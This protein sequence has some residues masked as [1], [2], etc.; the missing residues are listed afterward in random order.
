MRIL[1]YHEG[2]ELDDFDDQDGLRTIDGASRDVLLKSV[3]LSIGIVSPEETLMNGRT[4]YKFKMRSINDGHRINL[5]FH[6]RQKGIR[7][8]IQLIITKKVFIISTVSA[9]SLYLYKEENKVAFGTPVSFSDYFQEATLLDP[10]KLFPVNARP[11]ADE[12]AQEQVLQGEHGAVASLA[13]SSIQNGTRDM[14]EASNPVDE[15]QLGTSDD[16]EKAEIERQ[17]ELLQDHHS[18]MGGPKLKLEDDVRSQSGGTGVENEGSQAA[19]DGDHIKTEVDETALGTLRFLWEDSGVGDGFGRVDQPVI[20]DRRSSV[21]PKRSFAILGR[22]VHTPWRTRARSKS[23]V[24][25]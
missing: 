24:C 18:S 2:M 4:P 1:E 14:I 15:M 8:R 7:L 12:L 3:D 17:L 13:R 10:L 21:F 23:P 25:I 20:V 11:R 19:R 16:D 5:R 22:S 6:F 9:L